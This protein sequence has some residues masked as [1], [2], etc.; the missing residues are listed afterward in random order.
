MVKEY[1][2]NEWKEMVKAFFVGL[3][4]FGIYSSYIY[5][6]G[7][8]MTLAKNQFNKGYLLYERGDYSKSKDYFIESDKLWKTEENDTY[9]AKV[10]SYP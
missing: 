2:K 7:R 6:I 9:L 3:I 1:I 10:T 8:P 4:I 5:F